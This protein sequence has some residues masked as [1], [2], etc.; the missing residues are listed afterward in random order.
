MDDYRGWNNHPHRIDPS[1]CTLPVEM[2][3][4]FTRRHPYKERK[5]EDLLPGY[6]LHTHQYCPDHHHESNPAFPEVLGY[7]EEGFR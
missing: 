3:R 1:V 4:A 6:F 5:Y 7:E 2:V